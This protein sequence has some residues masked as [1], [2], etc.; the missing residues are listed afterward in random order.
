MEGLEK[1]TKIKSKEYPAITLGKAIE[2]V[3]KLKDYPRNK[4]ISYDT[5]AQAL[6]I[7]PTTKSFTYT[8]SASKQ[9]GLITTST[10]RTL[11][12]TERA[13]RLVRPTEDE[14]TL[15]KLKIECFS[16]PKLYS[17]LLNEYSGKS[18]PPIERLE[19]ILVTSFGIAPNAA[20]SA[21]MTFIESANE[22]CVIQNG[23]LGL[24]VEIPTNTD[25]MDEDMPLSSLNELQMAKGEFDAPLSIP[26][27]EQK[28]LY[29]ICHLM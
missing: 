12:L 18:I 23:I 21:A 13:I 22:V 17:N 2:F 25:A 15:L 20:N 10:G 3:E 9:F 5:A 8:I 19:N 7:K 6:H 28:K 11:S 1:K 29:Y 4:P 26:F 16:L 27:G 14:G 24:D